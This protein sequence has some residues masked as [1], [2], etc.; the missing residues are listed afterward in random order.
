[1]ICLQIDEKVEDLRRGSICM[2]MHFFL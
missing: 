1:L 2:H